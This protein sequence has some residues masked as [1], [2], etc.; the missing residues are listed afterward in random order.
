MAG[1]RETVLLVDDEALLRMNAA[2]L[3]EEAGYRVIEA[4]SADEA[5]RWL[6]LDASAVDVLMTDVHMPGSMDGIGLAQEVDRRWPHIRLVVTSARAPMSDD[7][8][9]DHGRFVAKPWSW[10]A[11]ARA[12]DDAGRG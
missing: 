7:D 3:L 2:D 8:I 11:V 6:E 1:R 12:L 5:L 10:P 4:A 9:P